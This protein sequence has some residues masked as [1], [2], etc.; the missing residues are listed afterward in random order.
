MAALGTV[1]PSEASLDEVTWTRD[2]GEATPFE[3]NENCRT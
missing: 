2:V 1:F 3:G